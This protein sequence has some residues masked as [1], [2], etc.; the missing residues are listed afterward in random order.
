MPSATTLIRL[1]TLP[2]TRHLLVAASRSAALRDLA[3][4]VRSDRAGLIGEVAHPARTLGLVREAVAHP[5][6]RELAS[7]GYLLLPAR[8]IPV[9]WVAMRLSHG[10]LGLIGDRLPPRDR[11]RPG[12]TPNAIDG[13]APA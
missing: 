5:A 7:V 3:R 2:E 6:T 10:I 13:D 9:G 12:A 8:Y 1:A 4:R 11:D